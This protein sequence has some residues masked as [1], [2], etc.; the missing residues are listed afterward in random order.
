MARR[1]PDGRRCSSLASRSLVR[2]GRGAPHDLRTPKMNR[3][4]DLFFLRQCRSTRRER[5]WPTS[6]RATERHF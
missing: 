4:T 2:L 3:A 1:L 6:P 5:H